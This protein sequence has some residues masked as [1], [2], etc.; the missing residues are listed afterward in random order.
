MSKSNNQCV[1]CRGLCCRYFGL[2]IDTP[3][4]AG[5]FDDI[6][7]YLLHKNTEVYVS[8]DDWYLN[9][10]NTCKHLQADYGCEIYESRPRICRGYS[11]KDCDV[12]SDEY[13]HEHHFYSAE[14]LA[15]YARGYLRQKRSLAQL[16]K[17]R[18]RRRAVK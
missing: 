17:S 15:E 9:V 14:Q 13:D 8:D 18:P 16:R 2:P 6:R 11:T 10:K 1:R 12:T 7:W 4:T 3:E 5:D